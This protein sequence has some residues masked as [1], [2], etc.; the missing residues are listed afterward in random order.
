MFYIKKLGSGSEILQETS[1]GFGSGIH[2]RQILVIRLSE[3]AHMS[4]DLTPTN[5]NV[6]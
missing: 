4:T 5:L 3:M 1:F 2:S 6:F